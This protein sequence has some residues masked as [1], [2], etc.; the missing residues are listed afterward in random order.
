MSFEIFDFNTDVLGR[1]V[2]FS[3]CLDM[4]RGTDHKIINYAGRGLLY[5]SETAYFIIRCMAGGGIFVDVGAHIGFFSILTGVLY[6][7]KVVVVACEPDPNNIKQ[8]LANIKLNNLYNINVLE[9]AISDHIGEVLFFQNLKNSGGSAL[10]N[11]DLFPDNKK[12][13]EIPSTIITKVRT[14][15][16]IIKNIEHQKIRLI[17]IDTEGAEQ[18]VLLGAE[19][20]LQPQNISYIIAELHEFG[21]SQFEHSQGSLRR[22]MQERGYECF[23]MSADDKIPKLIPPKT[24]ITSKFFQNLLFTTQNALS[25]LWPTEVIS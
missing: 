16:D 9:C 13:M 20:F 19:D 25:E 8:L 12:S 21:L 1:T 14:L 22:L 3:L 7:E 10:W 6:N 15:S 23:T 18:K 4:Q 5:E 2:K 24:K 17:K 11:P